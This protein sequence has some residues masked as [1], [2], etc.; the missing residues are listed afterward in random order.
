MWVI[1]AVIFAVLLIPFIGLITL[2]LAAGA[3][4]LGI[5]ATLLYLPY[6]DRRI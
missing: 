1:F 4:I 6:G 2:K 5:F 3:A